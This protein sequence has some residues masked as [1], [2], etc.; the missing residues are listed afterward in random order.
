[1][2]ILFD[3]ATPLPLRRILSGHSVSTAAQQGWAELRNG[4]LLQAAEN[5]G[6]ELL[7]TTDQNMQYQ[8]NLSNRK[9][10]I[11]VLGKG[12]WPLIEPHV[13]KVIAAVNAATPGSFARV[14]IPFAD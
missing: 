12:N 5:G 1:M 13:H 2:R 6:F 3:Q 9:M 4:D 11:V 14:D 7:L 10:A 8:Q